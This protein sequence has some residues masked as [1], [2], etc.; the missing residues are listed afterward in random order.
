VPV[1]IIGG[2]D[3]EPA[4][5]GSTELDWTILPALVAAAPGETTVEDPTISHVI[6]ERSPTLEGN[7][8]FF[9]VFVS[10]AR[11][12]AFVDYSTTGDVIAVG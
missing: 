1:E 11:S 8:V 2:G 3:I 4:L 6:V 7:P 5:F 10:G 12:S 9:R